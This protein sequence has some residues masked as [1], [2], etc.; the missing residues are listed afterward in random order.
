MT[1]KKHEESESG[2]RREFLLGAGAAAGGAALVGAS[3]S[4][5]AQ[6]AQADPAQKKPDPVRASAPH[7]THFRR[8]GP[9][10]DLSGTWRGYGFNLISLPDFHEGKP[11]RFLAN[12]TI[13]SLDFTS[14]GGPVPNRGSGQD[15]IMIHGLTYLQRVTDANTNGAL[16]IEPGIWLYVPPTTVPPNPSAT[17]VRLATIPHGNSLLAQG[18][19][20]QPV[21][22]PIID[23]VDPTP[24]R[25]PPGEPLGAGYLGPITNPTLP[26]GFKPEYV[27]NPNQALV[28][29]IAG[30]NIVKTVVLS[31]S[32]ATA[33]PTKQG[34]LNI[35]FVVSNA[36]ATRLDAIFW[37]ETIQRAD[38][39]QYLKLQYTQKIIL[40]FLNIDWPHISVATL[41]K[42]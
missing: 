29:A 38:G 32:T 11:F 16:H 8:L 41:V 9:L 27:K 13:E 34:I 5:L 36:N 1:E 10:A 23:P 35:P 25:N 40:N 14:I 33:D 26:N 30:D 3:S 21:V 28:D 2:T 24:V 22:R 7:E 39:S 18:N 6:D 37:I 17:V 4:A 12:T 31:V 15:D 19:E 42:Q 20:I